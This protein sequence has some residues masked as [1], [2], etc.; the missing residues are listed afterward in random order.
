MTT[1]II[2]N[3][4]DPATANMPLEPIEK[5]PES[6]RIHTIT[7]HHKNPTSLSIESTDNKDTFPTLDTWNYRLRTAFSNNTTDDSRQ[8][9]FSLILKKDRIGRV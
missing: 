9:P 6:P 3:K 2:P 1:S 8:I 4:I 7:K 5:T